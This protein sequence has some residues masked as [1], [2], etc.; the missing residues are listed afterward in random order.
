[1]LLASFGRL[2]EVWQLGKNQL[3]VN[4]MHN[5]AGVLRQQKALG[6]AAQW[7]ARYVGVDRKEPISARR[8]AGEMVRKFAPFF[9][10]NQVTFCFGYN[11]HWCGTNLCAKSSPIHCACPTPFKRCLSH[12]AVSVV[13]DVEGVY[14]FM[15]KCECSKAYYVGSS[16]N[17]MDR[18][19]SHF[20]GSRGCD[21]F[22]LYVFDKEILPSVS[23]LWTTAMSRDL[24]RITADWMRKNLCF[25]FIVT[26]SSRSVETKLRKAL[27]PVLNPL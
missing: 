17:L 10:N 1:M 25:D 4:V 9:Q 5:N 24:N 2:F 14:I 8:H 13:P 7:Y 26:K 16:G 6:E 18:I 15:K 20:S 3:C 21:Q 27:C 11:G 23:C 12:R 19:R 22:C